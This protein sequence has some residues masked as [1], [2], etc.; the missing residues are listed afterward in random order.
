[1][2]QTLA[3]GAHLAAEINTF[4]R[5]LLAGDVLYRR[6][7]QA[8]DVAAVLDRTIHQTSRQP[9]ERRNQARQSAE[10]NQCNQQPPHHPR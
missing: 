8:D 5:D 10:H 9:Q 3:A 7:S 2:L 6:S 1:M 4:L